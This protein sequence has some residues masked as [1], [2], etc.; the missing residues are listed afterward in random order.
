MAKLEIQTGE[1]N[2]ILRQKAVEVKDFGKGLKKMAKDMLETMIKANGLGLAAPQVGI[3]KRMFLIVLDYKSGNEKA[4]AMVNP[5][6]LAQS[7]ETELAEEG[8]LSLPDMFERVE[9]PIEITVEFSDLDGNRQ[10]LTLSGLNAREVLH[11]ND[12]LD[13]VLFTDRFREQERERA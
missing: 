12:H 5:V 3:S 11:E 10:V 13:G 2:P 1:D 4:I 8:C 7:K 9:R 6:I